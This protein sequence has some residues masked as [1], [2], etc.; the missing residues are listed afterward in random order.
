MSSSTEICNSALIKLG[1]ERIS[2]LSQSNKRAALCNEQYSKLRDAR[3]Q[4]HHW[5]FAI[6]RG[7]LSLL[8]SSP[9]FGFDYQYQLPSD[10]LKAIHLHDKTARFKVEEN[11]YLH[12]NLSQA[13]L[14]YVK[15]VT[16]ESK[17]SP[18]FRE[19]LAYDI[20]IDLCIALTQKRTLKLDLIDERKELLRDT[21]S[22]D[23]QEGTNDP[24]MDDVWLNSRW[25]DPTG[26]YGYDE[27]V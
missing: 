22:V 15:Q 24:L 14:L 6:S 19:L 7:Q 4:S 16:D 26:D 23:G 9:E 10:C 11:K 1:Q 3:L 21:R 13:E 25:G 18:M 27:S 20:A 12:T 8:S 2:S 5:N 17:Y